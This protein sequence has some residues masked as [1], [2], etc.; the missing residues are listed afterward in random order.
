MVSL[1]TFKSPG[2]VFSFV[3]KK[4]RMPI[5]LLILIP[6]KYTLLPFL[7]VYISLNVLS[8]LQEWSIKD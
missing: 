5:T 2:K 3:P 8:Y 6:M 1:I 7:V 4:L